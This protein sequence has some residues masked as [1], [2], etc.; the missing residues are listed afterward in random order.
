MSAI[1]GTLILL[2]DT[3]D[4]FALSTS[5]TLNIDMDL[6]DASH[7]GSAGW[8]EHIRGQK[9]WSVDLDGL[10]DFE[11]GT[12]GGVQDVVNYILNREN[13]QIEFV[14]LAGSFDGSKGVSYEGNASCA[15]VS[16]VASN[17][18]TCTLTGSFTGNGELAEVVVS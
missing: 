11:T 13:V 1:N 3:N 10:A 12:T 6:P 16:V 2:R 9:S 4:P 14:P 7:K 15:S 18:D 8:A 17:E 5:C